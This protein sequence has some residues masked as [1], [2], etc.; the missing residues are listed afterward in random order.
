MWYKSLMRGLVL[1]LVLA[2]SIQAQPGRGG[3]GAGGRG[4]TTTPDMNGTGN[5]VIRFM[6]NWTNTNAILIQDG[7]ETLMTAV[8]NYCGWF[9]AKTTAPASDFKVRFKQTIGYIYVGN[10]GEETVP[11][12]ALPITDEITLDTVAAKTDTIWIVG[13]SDQVEVFA[14]YPSLLGE[15]PIRTISVMMFDWYH[16]NKGDGAVTT[17]TDRRDSSV[18]TKYG[19]GAKSDDPEFSTSPW[20]G[21]YLVSNDFGSGGCGGSNAQDQNRNGYMRGMVENQLGPQGV[22]VRKQADFPENCKLTEW[23]DAWFL[24][25]YVG[26]DAA[27][28]KLTNAACRDVQLEMTD[29]GFWLGQKDG[30]SPEGGFFLL[31]DFEFLDAA[32]TIKNPMFDQL[33]AGDRKNHNFGFSMKFQAKFVYVKGQYFEFFGDDDVWVFINNRLVVDIGGQHAEVQRGVLDGQVRAT[34]N[35]IPVLRTS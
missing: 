5:T 27:G 16:G 14:A 11:S 10:E 29:D 28:N 9:Q 6:P 4:G 31:D 34:W 3:A 26:Q 17:T 24:P 19:N 30:N 8:K 1:C 15:C 13:H 21:A 32:K 35:A 22:P 7:K 25:Q 33:S 18:T 20:T 23:L 2:M 12:G